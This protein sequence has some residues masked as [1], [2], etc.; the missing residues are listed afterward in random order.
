MSK[1]TKWLL[2]LI[3]C[4][5]IV[6]I[7]VVWTIQD[8][9]FSPQP[10]TV[11][12][13]VAKVE[14]LY[15]ETAESFELLGDTVQVEL[16]KN[17]INYQFEVD[18][19]TGEIIITNSKQQ[20]KID[21]IQLKTEEEIRSLLGA[22]GVIQ[23]ITFQQDNEQYVAKITH[24]EMMKT[25]IVNA[26][27]GE[28]M[29]ETEVVQNPPAQISSITK[30]KAKQIAL[31]QLNGEVEYV[32]YKETRD[33]GHYLVEIDASDQEAIFQIHA[34]SGKVMSVTLD[35]DSVDDNDDDDDDDDD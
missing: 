23:S 8:R 31:S 28:I 25:V 35:Q 27:S 16:T 3:L 14:D 4:M 5:F 11:T 30:E 17:N 9:F 15:G 24:N 13:A 10:L 7:V 26:K 22:K 19:L 33:G 29:S 34:I 21:P 2:V 12:E 32:V 1:F 18:T 20:K 6:T